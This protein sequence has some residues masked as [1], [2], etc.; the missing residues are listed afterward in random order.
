MGPAA[1]TPLLSGM[2][3]V[4]QKLVATHSKPEVLPPPYG[5]EQRREGKGLPYPSKGIQAPFP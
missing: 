4:L 2:L 1:H 3:G 5:G